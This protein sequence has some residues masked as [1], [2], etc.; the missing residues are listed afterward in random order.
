MLAASLCN[1]RFFFKID[2]TNSLFSD[3]IANVMSFGELCEREAQNYLANSFCGC[4]GAPRASQCYSSTPR[5]EWFIALGLFPSLSSPQGAKMLFAPHPQEDIISHV[6]SISFFIS[7]VSKSFIIFHPKTY[8]LHL[9]CM[10][11]FYF[12]F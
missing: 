11:K 6:S 8:T 2:K 1:R 12:L 3:H 4:V 10:G 9:Y 7:N 5:G